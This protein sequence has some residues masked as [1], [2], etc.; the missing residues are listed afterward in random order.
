M[1]ELH[2][3]VTSCCHSDLHYQ[4]HHYGIIPLH[5]R[6]GGTCFVVVAVSQTLWHRTKPQCPEWRD[7]HTATSSHIHL[8]A[9]ALWLS[10]TYIPEA[11]IKTVAYCTQCKP[12]G[13]ELLSL[14]PILLVW[15]TQ[16]M[17]AYTYIKFH[18][19]IQSHKRNQFQFPYLCRITQQPFHQYT[20]FSHY[21]PYTLTDP[22]RYA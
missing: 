4:L 14:V 18:L 8:E 21:Q 17:Y 6:G 3:L 5:P 22:L 19:H 10:A 20:D 12:S 16:N 15:N 2:A 7:T 13:M 1:V 9:K 11:C